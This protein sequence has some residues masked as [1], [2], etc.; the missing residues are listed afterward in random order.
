MWSYSLLIMQVQVLVTASQNVRRILI[1]YDKVL[2]NNY[3]INMWFMW[4]KIDIIRMIAILYHRRPRINQVLIGQSLGSMN[5]TTHYI[6]GRSKY[7]YN[8]AT[9]TRAWL[10]FCTC[11]Y[12]AIYHSRL[13]Y[14]QLYQYK[15]LTYTAHKTYWCFFLFLW[16]C[17]VQLLNR[18][19][20]HWPKQ[21]TYKWAMENCSSSARGNAI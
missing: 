13:H 4:Y 14:F 20:E 3:F 21:D 12:Y 7:M 1:R 19:H 9:E 11:Q 10:K 5:H 6:L 18:M 8:R 17:L 16:V 15:I 2:T